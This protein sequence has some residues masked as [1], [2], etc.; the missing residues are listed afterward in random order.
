VTAI[1]IVVRSNRPT[2]THTT[3][4]RPSTIIVANYGVLGVTRANSNEKVADNRDRIALDNATELLN[5]DMKCTLLYTAARS[6]TTVM[7][8]V[9]QPLTH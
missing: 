1:F 6:S 2:S 5:C 3:L 7:T 4:N 9:V 8:N